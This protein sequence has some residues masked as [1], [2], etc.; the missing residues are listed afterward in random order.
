MAIW[1]LLFTNKLPLR[2]LSQEAAAGEKHHACFRPLPFLS[3]PFSPH[4]PAQA[5]HT[6]ALARAMGKA[7][8]RHPVLSAQP[9][10]RRILLLIHRI[11]A[12]CPTRVFSQTF[13]NSLTILTRQALGQALGKVHI[14]HLSSFPRQS[15]KWVHHLFFLTDRAPEGLGESEKFIPGLGEGAGGASQSQVQGAQLSW[16]A[17]QLH[18]LPSPEG[19]RANQMVT[20]R[21]QQTQKCC[22]PST[23]HPSDCCLR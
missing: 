23:A 13:C 17:Q 6:E 7:L 20:P 19:G 10:P 21:H 5:P 4:L 8:L 16:G 12:K 18:M 15:G 2:T 3:W 14:N 1:S 22:L 9:R 11:L